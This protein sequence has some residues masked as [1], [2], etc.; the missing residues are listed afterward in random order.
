[1]FQLTITKYLQLESYLLCLLSSRQL[2]RARMS[3]V[4]LDTLV[5]IVTISEDHSEIENGFMSSRSTGK[6]H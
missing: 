1:M 3:A 2:S 6:R 4:L 5:F